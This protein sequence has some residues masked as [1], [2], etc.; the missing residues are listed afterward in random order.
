MQ[1]KAASSPW[2]SGA[3][4]GQGLQRYPGAALALMGD[5]EPGFWMLSITSFQEIPKSKGRQAE[6]VRDVENISTAC[7]SKLSGAKLHL[8]Q[9][10]LYVNQLCPALGFQQP[11]KFF[12]KPC[13]IL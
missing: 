13:A 2:V 11:F 12:N 9:K 6:L 3:V 10:L 7:K 4:L 8:R 1:G 5:A